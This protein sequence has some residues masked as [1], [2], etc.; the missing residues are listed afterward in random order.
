MSCGNNARVEDLDIT[1]DDLVGL[2]R[3]I[4]MDSRMYVRDSS[5]GELRLG[6]LTILRKLNHKW[7]KRWSDIYVP[8]LPPSKP[9]LLMARTDGWLPVIDNMST[10]TTWVKGYQLSIIRQRQLKWKVVRHQWYKFN[11]DL[12]EGSSVINDTTDL[13]ER[14]P[15][16]N[17][18]SAKMIYIVVLSINAL[19]TY[20]VNNLC[21]CLFH[22]RLMTC[23]HF[24]VW[25]MTYVVAGLCG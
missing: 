24:F 3:W 22:Q 15:V 8:T 14:L 10:M 9:Q 20:I 18:T 4:L 25:L 7:L 16:I 2:R 23:S 13:S 21:G 12:S 19:M 1:L 5:E 11:D 6:P 17:N